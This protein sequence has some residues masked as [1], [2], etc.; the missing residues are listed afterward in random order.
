MPNLKTIKKILDVG[1]AKF[2]GLKRGEPGA[3]ASVLETVGAREDLTT[4]GTAMGT[5]SYMSPEQARGQLTDSRTDLF[6]VGTVLY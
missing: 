6:S 5:V 3:G 4:P 2:E 1:L